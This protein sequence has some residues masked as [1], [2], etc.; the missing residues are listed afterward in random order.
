MSMAS[1]RSRRS[2]WRRTE[3]GTWTLSLGE[4]GY[5]VRLCEHRDKGG[6]IYR[7]VQ[8]RGDKKSRC[9][10]GTHDRA[11][12]E[13]MGRRI[14][15]GLMSGREPQVPTGPLKLGALCERFL[16][17]CPMFLDNTAKDRGE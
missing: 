6:M 13:E 17:E 16:A 2:Q 12:A 3:N 7:E 4:R 10:L 15:A 5:R 1:R 11:R 14:V 9:S 8:L